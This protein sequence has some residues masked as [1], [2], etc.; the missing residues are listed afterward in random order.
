M[1][2][3]ATR[4]EAGLVDTA[5]AAARARRKHLV[6]AALVGL[7]C[8]LFTLRFGLPPASW[9]LDRSWITVLAWAYQNGLQWGPDVVFTYGP[10]AFTHHSA[11]YWA[12]LF[13][14]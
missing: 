2:A 11:A 4:I 5:P 14:A 3:S 8:G 10:Y 1:R 13:D 7:A 9:Q 6:L 12:P